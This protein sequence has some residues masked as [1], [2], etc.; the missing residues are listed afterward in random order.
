MES[1]VFLSLDFF[2]PELLGE[3]RF[4][5]FSRVAETPFLKFFWLGGVIS[6]PY[7]RTPIFRHGFGHFFFHTTWF[8]SREKAKNKSFQFPFSVDYILHNHLPKG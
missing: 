7:Q 4:Y 2:Q 8:V 3:P 1:K 6:L 5:Y